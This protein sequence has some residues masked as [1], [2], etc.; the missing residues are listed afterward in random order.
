MTRESARQPTD[1]H[2]LFEQ[3]VNAGDWEGVA[4]LYEDGAVI[5]GRSDAELGLRGTPDTNRTVT[6]AAPRVWASADLALLVAQW[7]VVRTLPNGERM[8]RHR[9]AVSVARRGPDGTWRYA[10]DEPALLDVGAP[11]F[12]PSPLGEVVT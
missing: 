2:R 11:A 7:R 9:I 10:V 1:L 8:D 6:V 3:R 12:V 5:G 4:A